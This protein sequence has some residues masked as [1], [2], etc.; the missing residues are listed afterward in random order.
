MLEIKPEEVI[1]L[2][3]ISN[4]FY[5]KGTILFIKNKSITYK[6]YKVTDMS[7]EIFLKKEFIVLKNI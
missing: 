3:K 7:F 1:A 2:C 4:K 6:S 5:K